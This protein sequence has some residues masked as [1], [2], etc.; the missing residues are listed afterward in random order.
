MELRDDTIEIAKGLELTRTPN[1]RSP[2][3]EQFERQ[4]KLETPE[5]GPY[6]RYL[7]R[8]EAFVSNDRHVDASL[9]LPKKEINDFILSISTSLKNRNQ[10]FS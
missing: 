5:E 6:F 3:D 2:H 4:P 1:G 9:P 8:A 7:Q 10:M